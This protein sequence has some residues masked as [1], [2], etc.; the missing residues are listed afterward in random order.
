MPKK[1]SKN[2]KTKPRVTFSDDTKKKGGKRKRRKKTRKKT[3][4]RKK[5]TRKRK[6]KTRKRKKK[7]GCLGSLC[8]TNTYN[9][10]GIHP[11]ENNNVNEIDFF[12]NVLKNKNPELYREIID[13]KKTIKDLEHQLRMIKNKIYDNG[14]I[15]YN[16]RTGQWV[17]PFIKGSFETKFEEYNNS[18]RKLIALK[19]RALILQNETPIA[20]VMERYS[21]TIPHAMVTSDDV[22][23]PRQN[24]Q[25]SN[26][27]LRNRFRRFRRRRQVI[28]AV[29]L[30][31]Q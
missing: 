9:V 12:E 28:P 11:Q 18:V 15:A 31:N 22:T 3:R 29:Q 2:K 1:T 6:K 30:P 19:Q 10:H 21:D 26:D 8:R 13:E 4:K 24:V 25:S 7:A 5:K 16:P 27:N 14:D 23:V 20:P 17:S